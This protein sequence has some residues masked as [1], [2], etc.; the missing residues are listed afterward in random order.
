MYGNCNV[1]CG[2]MKGTQLGWYDGL[3]NVFIFVRGAV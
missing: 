2:S 3:N 1:T